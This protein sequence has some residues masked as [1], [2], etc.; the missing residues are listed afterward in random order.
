MLVEDR[1]P[2]CLPQPPLNVARKRSE[3]ENSSSSHT[4]THLKDAEK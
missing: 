1:L 2:A 4:Q 3:S